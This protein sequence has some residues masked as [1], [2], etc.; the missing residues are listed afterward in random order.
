M[1]IATRVMQCLAAALLLVAAGMGAAQEYP[2][3]IVRIVHPFTAGSAGDTYARLIAKELQT[4]WDKPFIVENRPVVGTDVVRQSP[5]D[6]YTILVS[7][8]SA[9][10]LAPLLKDPRPY[11]PAADFTPIAKLLKFPLYLVV[12]PSLPVKTLQ[13]FVKFARAHPNQLAFASGGSGSLSHI[14]LELFNSSAG[15]KATL[16]PYKGAAPSLT[17]VITGEALYVLNNTQDSQPLVQAGRLRGLAVTGDKRSPV[18]PNTPT[19]AESGV[20]GLENAYTWFGFLGPARLTPAVLTRLSA[21]LNRIMRSP[22]MTKRLAQEGQ[23]LAVNT[24]DEFKSEIQ[25]E[26]S[27]WAKVIRDHG[28]KAD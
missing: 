10:V 27:V 26:I 19:M 6:G 25:Q 21:E 14:G 2:N 18:L 13:D 22:D 16:V 17:A 20:P 9:H 4:A 3:K 23:L 5:P 7:T 28:I 1:G 15:I 8:S 12:H 11:D 24:P